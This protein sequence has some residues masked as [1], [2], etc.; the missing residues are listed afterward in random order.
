MKKTLILLLALL[1]AA[2]SCGCR[3]MWKQD[4]NGKTDTEAPATDIPATEEPEWEPVYFGP[5][6]AYSYT[7]E[8][9]TSARLLEEDIIQF[10]NDLLNPYN[11][12][13]LL[14]DRDTSV[15]AYYSNT[16]QGCTTSLVNMYDPALREEFI[17]RINELIRDLPTFDSDYPHEAVIR[18]AEA[19]AILHD[20][21]TSLFAY[22]RYELPLRVYPF[23]S[24]DGCELRVI[25][26]PADSGLD[27]IIYSRIDAI[28][29]VPIAECAER[30]SACT[31]SKSRARPEM[32]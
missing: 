31:T 24:D 21:H 25:G 27:D 14:T 4:A 18:L 20:T 19:A 8:K 11:G 16:L 30:I 28:N 32:P 7:T 26:V 2:C 13:P 1:T 10:A 3:D 15:G 5:E 6:K 12:H 23:F 9:G 22:S 29:G 17:R